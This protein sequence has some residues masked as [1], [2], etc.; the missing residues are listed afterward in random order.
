MK[1]IQITAGLLL[2][3]C[4]LVINS[5]ARKAVL[6]DAPPDSTKHILETLRSEQVELEAILLT[7]SHWDHFA[8]ANPIK[9]STGAKLFLHKNDY[10]RIQNP[11]EH[12]LVQLDFEI[13][14]VEVDHLFV[15]QELLVFETVKLEAIPTPGHTEGGMIYV[16][17][18]ERCAFVGDT[19]F[20][21]SVGRTDLPGGNSETLIQS[22]NQIIFRLPDDFVLYPGHDRATTVGF[23]KSFNPYVL[24]V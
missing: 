3:N 2:T 15:E 19:I 24:A 6:I 17:D 10:Y 13:E 8:D 11:L 9:R 5:E 22:I 1:I 21:L 23:E 20:Y 4:Y 12:T 16:L 14:P 7:H 18:S